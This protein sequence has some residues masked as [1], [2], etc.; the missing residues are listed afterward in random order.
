MHTH[1]EHPHPMYPP[2]PHHLHPPDGMDD[3]A[4]GLQPPLPPPPPPPPGAIVEVVPV[5]VPVGVG[6]PE[7]SLRVDLIDKLSLVELRCPMSLRHSRIPGGVQPG[8]PPKRLRG[9]PDT[10]NGVIH[11]EAKRVMIFRSHQGASKLALQISLVD[12]SGLPVDAYLHEGAPRIVSICDA[13]SQKV[14][15]ICCDDAATVEA[16]F[17]TIA[18]RLQAK[19]KMTVER[20]GSLVRTKR[21]GNNSSIHTKQRLHALPEPSNVSPSRDSRIRRDHPHTSNVPVQVNAPSARVC[22]KKL[23]YFKF[24]I[25]AISISLSL[26][27]SP[28]LPSLF[29]VS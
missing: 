16:L 8:L 25:N 17:V 12:N 27:L 14:V 28:P 19:V 26:S 1:L 24:S 21:G 7:L 23:N 3:L 11:I 2:P 13:A 18:L 22:K 15:E 29:V 9:T 10:F 4:M 20:S 6:E 5:A